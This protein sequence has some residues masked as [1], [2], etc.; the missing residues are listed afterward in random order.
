MTGR[1][2]AKARK[3]VMDAHAPIPDDL[4]GGRAAHLLAVYAALDRD[5]AH[6]RCMPIGTDFEAIITSHLL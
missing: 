2:D 4:I 5:F 1:L 3:T 6:Q